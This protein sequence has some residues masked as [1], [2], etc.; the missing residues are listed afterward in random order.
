VTIFKAISELYLVFIMD[1]TINV[2]VEFEN[3]YG[4]PLIFIFRQLAF[5]ISIQKQD[6]VF[7]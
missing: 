6:W 3:K 1:F 2:P 7:L 5:S 4:Q